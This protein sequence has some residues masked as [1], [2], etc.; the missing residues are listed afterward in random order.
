MKTIYADIKQQRK[1]WQEFDVLKNKFDVYYLSE[2]NFFLVY[3][4]PLNSRN[5]TNDWLVKICVRVVKNK[6]FGET[7]ITYNERN[8]YVNNYKDAIKKILKL[9]K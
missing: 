5:T 2:F 1:M 3:L 4:F 7:T 6:H 8:V 9:N